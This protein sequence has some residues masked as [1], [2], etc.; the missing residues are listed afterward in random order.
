MDDTA[1]E[2]ALFPPQPPSR[3]VRPEPE[4]ADAHRELQRHKGMTLRLPGLEYRTVRPNG[5]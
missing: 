1:L 4:W 2:A 5:Y 3:V